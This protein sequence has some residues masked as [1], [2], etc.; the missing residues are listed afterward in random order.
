MVIIGYNV[1]EIHAYLLCLLMEQL[2]CI[3]MSYHELSHTILVK[4]NVDVV[5]Y[6]NF[7]FHQRKVVVLLELKR[8]LLFSVSKNLG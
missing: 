7:C 6:I 5:N 3:G 2:I 1:L 4:G 8:K